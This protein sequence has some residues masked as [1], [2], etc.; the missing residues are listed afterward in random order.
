MASRLLGNYVLLWKWF[1]SRIFLHDE[2]INQLAPLVD[3]NSRY[4]AQRIIELS[5]TMNSAELRSE[6]SSRPQ[7]F[8]KKG[9][10]IRR[11]LLAGHFMGVL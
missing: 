4:Q 6:L 7:L 1:P 8:R 10:N 2:L 9:E 3:D 11:D 5:N